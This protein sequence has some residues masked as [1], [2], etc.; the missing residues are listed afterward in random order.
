VC[1]V[2][3]FV[4][5]VV[6]D[7]CVFGV[8]VCGWCA[9]QAVCLVFLFVGDLLH[10]QITNRQDCGR[11]FGLIIGL[12]VRDNGILAIWLTLFALNH[13]VYRRQQKKKSELRLY[14]ILPKANFYVLFDVHFFNKDHDTTR[15]D[16]T[17][18]IV[19]TLPSV[20]FNAH[21]PS[22]LYRN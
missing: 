22:Y 5:A 10:K 20:N 13:A 16:M 19:N 15:H 2:F 4:G 8:L 12:Q 17:L 21:L 6:Q 3:W 7:V 14:N 11:M 18:I 9:S 1:V